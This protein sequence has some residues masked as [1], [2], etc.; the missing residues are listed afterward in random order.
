MKKEHC[1][2]LGKLLL[3]L[4][5]LFVIF[6]LLYVYNPESSNWMIR[7]AFKQIT[8]LSCP[9]CG[10]QRCIHSL[11]K[12]EIFHAF[13]YNFFLIIA[14]PFASTLLINKFLPDSSFKRRMDSIINNK[15]I[16]RSFFF[17]S[18]GWFVIRN[19]LNI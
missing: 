9:G 13:K 18:C 7:C 2:I 6:L 8:G 3:M 1:L 4:S 19:I 12:G 5:F 11:T 14:F 10:V 15:L 17:S 16:V